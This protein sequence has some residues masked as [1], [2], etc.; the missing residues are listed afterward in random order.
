VNR[1]PSIVLYS[2]SPSQI[3]KALGP[4]AQVT[5][6]NKGSAK[7]YAV[8]LRTEVQ[9]FTGT[10]SNELGTLAPGQTYVFN[11][12]PRLSEKAL[13]LKNSTDTWL[14]LGLEYTDSGKSQSSKMDSA[15]SLTDRNEFDWDLPE[16]ASGWMD[17][18]DNGLANFAAD[19][20][21]KAPVKVDSERE[22]AARQIYNHLQA[23]GMKNSVK[24]GKCYSGSLAFPAETMESQR[25]DCADISILYATLLE[26]AGVKSM[27][28]ITDD[29]VLSGFVFSN[30]T[31]VPVDLRRI[32]EDSFENATASG[33]SL[34][35]SANTI[36]YP[37]E[38]WSKGT[39]KSNP[40]I[41]TYGPNIITASDNCVLLSKEFNVNYWFENKGYETGRRCLKAVLYENVSKD[42][43]SN[44]VCVDVPAYEKR[45]VT[46]S[47]NLS[48]NATL[49]AK[50][51]ID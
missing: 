16:A 28:I 41:E 10:T 8:K 22:R 27:V 30:G 20:I 51:F 24:S 45:N 6:V 38:Q 7:A 31:T 42:Y 40:G 33:L 34:Y 26:A 2:V 47:Y 43:L 3:D 44:R 12:T 13:T 18:T 5:I 29:V 4:L 39:E 9:G 11:Y 46:F 25:G 15:I 49:T 21:A 23:M 14:R 37:Q 32:D 1:I 50:C 48:G 35:N 17:P 19:A 36:F